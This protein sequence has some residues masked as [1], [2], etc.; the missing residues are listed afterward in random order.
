MSK[1]KIITIG[2]LLAL[3]TTAAYAGN[4][5]LAGMQQAGDAVDQT[6]AFGNKI[7]KAIVVFSTWALFIG[8]LVLTNYFKTKQLDKMENKQG[9]DNSYMWLW[10][11]VAGVFVISMFVSGFIVIMLWGRMIPITG[12]IDSPYASI[13]IKAVTGD[14]S[15]VQ[16]KSSSGVT[17]G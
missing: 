12:N 14:I 3:I 4:N 2:M 7:F 9:E 6:L 17:L 5:D 8:G 11:K 16:S 10:V 13:I 15:A 1:I